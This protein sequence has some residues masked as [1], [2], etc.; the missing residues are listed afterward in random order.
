VDPSEQIL[1][2]KIEEFQLDENDVAFS[3]SDRLA[4]DNGWSKLYSSRVVVEYKKYLFLCCISDKGVT[5]SD[6]VDQ[7]WHLHL[8][9]TESYWVKLCRNT[10]NKE[11]HHN[12]TKGGTTEADKFD[13]FYSATIKLYHQ[14]FGKPPVDI[15]PDNETRFSDINFSR[16]NLSRYLLIRKPSLQ[17]KRLTTL[18]VIVL[19][20]LTCIQASFDFTSVLTV[21][22]L[23]G[24]VVFIARNLGKGGNNSGC[25]TGGCGT[26]GHSGCSSG[27][28]GCSGSGCSGC[29]S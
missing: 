5:P 26:S 8:T 12:P 14:Y 15:W 27:C 19:I 20:S 22:L 1:W 17:I 11:I 10:I 6:A 4:R 3:F 28:S 13:S 29:S 24:L 7:A 25:S 2:G 23:I 9:Y 16:V 21:V 18:L